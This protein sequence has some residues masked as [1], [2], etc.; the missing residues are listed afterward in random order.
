MKAGRVQVALVIGLTLIIM[1]VV[2]F[3]FSLAAIQRS[4][5]I[6]R[7]FASLENSVL[8]NLQ[9]TTAE[10][11]S[12]IDSLRSLLVSGGM[13]EQHIVAREFLQNAQRDLDLILTELQ[14]ESDRPYFR[15]F[16]TGNRDVWIGF[17]RSAADAAYTF[18]KTF[19]PGLS[20]EKFF[21][22]KEPLV[23]TKYT[24]MLSREAYIRTASPENVYLIFS[25]FGSGKLVVMPSVEVTNI[26]QRFDLYIPGQ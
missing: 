15:V 3:A 6:A 17:K 11:T 21:Y 9:D 8:R 24:V 5:K 14:E 20:D 19:S 7:E 2:A 1:S 18:Q 23:E 25:G 16:V 4:A 10:V 26:G 12:Q 22:F 13:L